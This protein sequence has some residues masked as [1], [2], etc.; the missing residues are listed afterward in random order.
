MKFKLFLT[1]VLATT[2]ICQAA[3]NPLSAFTGHYRIKETIKNGIIL[4]RPSEE[5]VDRYLVYKPFY[6]DTHLQE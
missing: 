3:T 2:A 6:L 5:F 4:E 1:L